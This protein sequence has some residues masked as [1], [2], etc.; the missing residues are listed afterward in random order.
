MYFQTKINLL[1]FYF[2]LLP[3]LLE[4]TSKYCC[5]PC[6]QLNRV[7]ECPQT[8]ANKQ[9]KYQNISTPETGQILSQK[10]ASTIVS[11]TTKEP[12]FQ[13]N[14]ISQTNCPSQSLAKQRHIA[15]VAPVQ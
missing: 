8:P 10:L 1:L 7:C 11:T 5:G 12:S 3:Y 2:A 13:S 9:S 14:E 4:A 6:Q 15:F